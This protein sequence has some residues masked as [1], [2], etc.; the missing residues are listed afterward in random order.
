[1]VGAMTG[2]LIEQSLGLNRKYRV[3]L[4][5]D[6]DFRSEYENLKDSELDIQIKKHRKRRS[7]NANAYLHVLIGKIAE[8][9]GLGNEEV[10]KALVCEYGALA[11]DE[12]GLTVGFKLPASVDVSTIYPYVKCFDTRVEDGKS[13]SCYLVYKQTHL[14]DSLEMAHL[15]DGVILVAQELEIQTDTPEQ[16]AKYKTC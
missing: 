4:E 16:V 1:M 11:K 5:L 7:L 3:T 8:A 15:I 6:K 12:D 9:Q 13:F 14:M 2:R 10:K